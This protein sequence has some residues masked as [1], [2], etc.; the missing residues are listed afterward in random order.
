VVLKIGFKP[1]RV[2]GGNYSTLGTL[3]HKLTFSFL[4]ALMLTIIDCVMPVRHVIYSM[5][6]PKVSLTVGLLG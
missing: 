2:I 5:L 1:E 4:D 6:K 3:R